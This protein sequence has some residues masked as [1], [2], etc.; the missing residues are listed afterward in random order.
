VLACEGCRSEGEE[1]GN[2]NEN[3]RREHG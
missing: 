2:Q 1:N 3:G